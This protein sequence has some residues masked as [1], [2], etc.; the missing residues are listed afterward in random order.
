MACNSNYVATMDS[1]CWL[2]SKNCPHQTMCAHMEE[3]LLRRSRVAANRCLVA[4]TAYP[5]IALRDN[6]YGTM[7]GNPRNSHDHLKD[8]TEAEDLL[9][10]HV[11]MSDRNHQH[12]CPTANTCSRIA[13]NAESS[14][15]FCVS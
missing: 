15:R 12:H 5:H 3:E 10:Q 1:N 2:S 13:G 9:K 11:Y 7:I 6:E 4:K 8:V 14:L